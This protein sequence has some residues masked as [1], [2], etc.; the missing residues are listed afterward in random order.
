MGSLSIFK[1]NK[2][3]DYRFID[4]IISQAFNIGG[5]LI[6]VH[7]YIGP[8][9]QGDT[10]DTTLN[11]DPDISA[12]TIQDVLLM[13]NRDRTYDPNVIDLKAN[14]TVN[15]LD[16]NLT[17]FGITT[18]ATNTLY[19]NFHINDMIDAV[20]RKIIPGDVVEVVHR[21]DEVNLDPTIPYIPAYY[22]VRDTAKA[23]DGYSPTWW[24]H[25]WRVRVEPMPDSQEFQQILNATQPDS[26]NMT[27][28]DMIS[29]YNQTIAISNAI[30]Q[31]GANEVPT[32]NFNSDA[33]WIAPIGQPLTTDNLIPWPFNNDGTPPNMNQVAPSGT[34]FPDSPTEGQYFLRMDY[35]P[36]R[37]FQRHGNKWCGVQAVWRDRAWTPAHRSLEDALDDT[38][39]TILSPNPIDQFPTREPVSDAIPADQ[40]LPIVDPNSPDVL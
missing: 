17:S 39:T 18:V 1:P 29:T 2:S 37:L 6:H 13:E 28:Q 11:S 38:E 36:P 33:L 10:D 30:A 34:R 4:K 24:P 7:K 26:G 31:E 25:I 22:V 12:L 27:L 9:A 14:Y 5:T 19:L 15:D 40:Q 32:R 3:K 21:R 35:A 16:F 20:G 8:I 23:A